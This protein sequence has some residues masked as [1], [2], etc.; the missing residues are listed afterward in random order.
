M[1]LACVTLLLG[2]DLKPHQQAWEYKAVTINKQ[3]NP[4]AKL[5]EFGADGWELVTSKGGEA[6]TFVIFKRAKQ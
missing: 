3:P 1:G 6:F 2:A 5:K 4:T